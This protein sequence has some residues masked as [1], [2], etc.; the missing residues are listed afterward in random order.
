MPLTITDMLLLGNIEKFTDELD[1][2]D[3]AHASFLNQVETLVSEIAQPDLAEVGG[4][5]ITALQ[6][7]KDGQA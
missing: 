1:K 2:D 5:I 6:A 4:T 7:I 3:P